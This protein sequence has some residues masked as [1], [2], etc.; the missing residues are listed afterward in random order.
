MWTSAW[1]LWFSMSNPTLSC[2]K[3]CPP[4]VLLLMIVSLAVLSPSTC[5]ILL[6]LT[7]GILLGASALPYHI[8]TMIL[9]PG[10]YH[11]HALSPPLLSLPRVQSRLLCPRCRGRSYSIQPSRL[12][13][14]SPTGSSG[15][16]STVRGDARPGRDRW[17]TNAVPHQQL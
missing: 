3:D 15:Q 4:A 11:P 1:L 12:L 17:P 16:G 7:S 14:T 8:L 9:Q 13:L 5:S 6:E 10:F 2:H